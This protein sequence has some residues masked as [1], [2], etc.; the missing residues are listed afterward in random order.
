ML[1]VALANRMI[2][3]YDTRN[4]RQ[5]LQ[6]R[7]SSLKF[8]TRCVRVAA[9][10]PYGFICT[11]IEG[12]VAVEYFDPSPAAQAAKYAFKCHREPAPR[13]PGCEIVFPVNTAAFHPV[14]GTFCTGGS[15]GVVSLWDAK[16]KKR[17][18]NYPRLHS[19]IS[20]MAF[21]PDGSRLAMAAS[22]T[23]D[24]GEKE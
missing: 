17:I 3:I 15:D 20:S 7:E 10:N 6:T 18:R 19:G 5:P 14:Y 22:Y 16:C 23:F 11:S 12:R 8:Q 13:N 24:E 21:A 2:N 4:F 9:P 1:V